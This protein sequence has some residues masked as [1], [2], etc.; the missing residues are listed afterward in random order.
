MPASRL[1]VNGHI[2]HDGAMA[3]QCITFD[4]DDTLWEVGP[5]I[6]RAEQEFYDWLRRR[7]PRVTEAFDLEALTLQRRAYFR[8]FPDRMHDLTGL[9]KQ[10]LRDLFETFGYEEV[11][12]EMAFHVFWEHRNAV[13]LFA[14]APPV[15]EQLRERYTLGVITNGNACVHHIGIGHWFDFVVSSE[16]AGHSKPAPQIFHAALEHAGVEPPRVVH[17]GD[18]PTNDVLG[19][20]AVGMRTVWYNP[21]LRPWPGGAVPDAVIRSMSELHRAVSR[22]AG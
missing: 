6:M 3:I 14:E 10:W 9:R 21:A 11:S 22:I 4:L 7:C 1:P 18:D 16:T 2:P 5:V 8:R 17:V 12:V 13:E 20:S 19:A 15:M